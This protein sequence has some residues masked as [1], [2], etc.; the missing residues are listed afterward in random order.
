MPNARYILL[1]ICLF[2]VK[3]I[4]M[5]LKLYLVGIIFATILA[6]VSFF[7]L[8]YFFSPESA[9]LGLLILVFL[10]LFISLA[11]VFGLM[12]FIFRKIAYKTQP[13]FRFLGI[14]FRQGTLLAILAVGS[15]ILRNFHFFWFWS[16]LGL[17]AAVIII[18]ILFLRR[19]E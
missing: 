2:S 18:E 10:S 3:I 13:A 8:I 15:L 14:S 1:K 19:A 11:G 6:L 12:G 5:T 7:L 16:G 17:L 4:L 9:D